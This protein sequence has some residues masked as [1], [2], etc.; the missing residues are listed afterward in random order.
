MTNSP[1]NNKLSISCDICTAVHVNTFIHHCWTYALELLS[2]WDA[3][4]LL[5][6]AQQYIGNQILDSVQM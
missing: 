4:F 3:Q 6:E 1:A 5:W 2:Y